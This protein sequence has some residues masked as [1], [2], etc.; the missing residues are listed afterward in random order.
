MDDVDEDTCLRER[1]RGT[2]RVILGE[3]EGEGSTINCEIQGVS[4]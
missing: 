3:F 2:L 4:R 1:Q